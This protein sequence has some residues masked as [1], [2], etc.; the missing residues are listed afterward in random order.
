MAVTSRVRPWIAT[1]P[2][3]LTPRRWP[4]PIDTKTAST[5]TPAACSASETAFLVA[6]T[7]DPTLAA[8]PFP[9]SRGG[10]L[11]DSDDVDTGGGDLTDDGAHLGGS[12][13]EPGDDVL[14]PTHRQRRS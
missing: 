6:S 11:A 1:T 3:L 7:V 12:H 10:V 4:P 8:K 9:K 13:I 2:W 5:S 14:R